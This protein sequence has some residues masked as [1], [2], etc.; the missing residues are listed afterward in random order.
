LIPNAISIAE[1][2][3]DKKVWTLLMPGAARRQLK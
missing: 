3:I 2:A 1:R